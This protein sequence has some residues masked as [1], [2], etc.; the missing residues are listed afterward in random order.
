MSN[1]IDSLLDQAR[2][3]AEKLVDDPSSFVDF[4]Y[5]VE[6][7]NITSYDD[8]ESGR[9]DLVEMREEKCQRGMYAKCDMKAG[10]YL[11]ASQPVAV[12]WDVENEE[13]KYDD[14]GRGET[15][16][17]DTHNNDDDDDNHDSKKEGQ[18]VLRA[19]EKIK[20]SPTIW[21]KSLTKLYPRDIRTASKLPPWICGDVSIR[22]EVEKQM[23]D[24]PSLSLF[25][26]RDNERVCNEIA[27]RLPLIIR[28]NAFIAETF[29]EQ[30]SYSSL[31]GTKGNGM[32]SLAGAGLYGPE[33][34][35]FNHSCT[36]NLSKICI[37]DV[38]FLVTNRNVAT[39]DELCHS[40]LSHEYLCEEEEIRNAILANEFCS[41]LE[42][43]NTDDDPDDKEPPTKR[44]RGNL[45]TSGI[46][47]VPH[48]VLAKKFDPVTGE[49]Y[50][51]E[52]TERIFKC[53]IGYL[54]HIYK[55]RILESAGRSTKHRGDKKLGLEHALPEWEAAIEFAEATFPPLDVRKVALYVQAS[56]CASVNAFDDWA[57][58]ALRTKGLRVGDVEKARQYADKAYR[59]HNDV[60]GGGKMRFLKRYVDEFLSSGSPKRK[61]SEAQLLFS[62][63]HLW[64]FTDEMWD[65]LSA[66]RDRGEELIKES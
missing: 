50:K 46:I 8:I 64:G 37:G 2:A 19:L 9:H 57:K 39:G 21:K 4:R 49:L 25:D 55:A 7:K 26:S 54:F 43:N 28:Y 48:F 15:T 18:L 11:I 36:P 47:C 5:T 58:V 17:D 14:T 22:L 53:N 35:Y 34:S 41:G 33:L 29:S 65:E 13:V 40:Y 66:S 52:G 42:D 27:V 62:L 10:T 63:Q 20:S 30:F 1:C 12:C 51:A 56:L 6:S 3:Y 31:G 60:F 16:A 61:I 38:V 59:M 45:Q 24:L 23:A 44:Q 32:E